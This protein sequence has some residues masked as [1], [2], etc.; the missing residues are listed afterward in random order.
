MRLDVAG[1]GRAVILVSLQGVIEVVQVGWKML[2]ICAG[3]WSPM[4]YARSSGSIRSASILR[5]SRSQGFVSAILDYV[6]LRCARFGGMA[7]VLASAHAQHWLLLNFQGR[8]ERGGC[9]QTSLVFGHSALTTDIKHMNYSSHC[10]LPV[11]HWIGMTW[12]LH[13]REARRIR[14]VVQ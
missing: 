3:S 14:P 6:C 11:Q 4:G 7:I 1:E 10:S 13:R 5:A 8:R 9:V 12:W 2:L